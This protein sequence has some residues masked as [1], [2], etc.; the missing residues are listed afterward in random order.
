MGSM[1]TDHPPLAEDPVRRARLVRRSVIAL[2]V[3]GIG[4]MIFGSIGDNN[5]IAITFGIVTAVAVGF[6]ILLTAVVGRGAFVASEG[7][8]ATERGP[9][10]DDRIAADVEARVQRLVAEGADEH[11]IRQLVTRAVD[12]G[13]DR[14]GLTGSSPSPRGEP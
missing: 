9:R 1:E 3:I 14:R 10:V 4:G 7:D 2:S 11:E 12:L 8:R 5:G 13:R 6:L